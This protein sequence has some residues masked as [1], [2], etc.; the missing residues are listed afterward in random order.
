MGTMNIP[1]LKILSEVTG[2]PGREE[3]VREIV[4]RELKGLVDEVRIDALGNLIALKRA[5]VKPKKNSSV[6]KVMLSA[7]MD[8]IGFMVKFIDDKG[9]LR[10]QQ[11]GGFDPR[12][13][14]ARQVV[15]CSK[16]G[17]LPGILQPSGRP[18]HIS[19]TED[20][21]KNPEIKQFFVD[22]GLSP[23]EVK[24][25]VR[26]GD[27]VGLTQ[28]FREVGAYVAGK[29]LDD[30]IWVFVLLETLKALKGKQHKDD[31]YAVFSVQEEIGLRGAVVAA[32]GIEPDIGIGLDTTLAVDIPGVGNEESVTIT[33]DGVGIKVFDSSM[34]ATHWLVEEFSG[35]ADKKKIKYQ[36]EVLPLG[37]TDAG[38]IQ[39]S[40][41]GVSSITL[42]LPSRYVHTVQETV[43]KDDL[44][45]ALKLLTA[46]LT[47]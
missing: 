41:T 15:V 35:L 5:T 16:D 26:I 32:Y 20:R 36:L 24:K 27:P 37:G 28:T 42:S 22:T 12:N 6:R 44:S 10:V 29:C 34:V 13:L 2:V 17:D 11:L 33:G 25:K 7:H 46:W 23:D 9:F 3:R 47:Q 30:R 21:A 8:E 40:R 18:I 38:A 19:S 31:I 45:A 4:Q 43:H 39:R 14:F 1:L